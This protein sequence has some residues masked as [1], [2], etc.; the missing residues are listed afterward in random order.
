MA[1]FTRGGVGMHLYSPYINKKA[2]TH[3]DSD[4]PHPEKYQPRKTLI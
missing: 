1:A 4:K 2:Q 3:P